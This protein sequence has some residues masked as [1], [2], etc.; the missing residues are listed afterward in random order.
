MRVLAA[1]LRV[2][3]AA[4]VAGADVEEAVGA[5][6]DHAAVVVGREVGDREHDDP[7]AG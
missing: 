3:A 7:L 4:A 2:A 6:L 1:A 5:E